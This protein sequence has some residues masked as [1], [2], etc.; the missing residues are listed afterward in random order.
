MSIKYP[1]LISIVFAFKRNIDFSH[2]LSNKQ[3]DLMLIDADGLSAYAHAAI[4][5]NVQLC[6]QLECLVLKKA[7]QLHHFSS[8]QVRQALN[9][10]HKQ[11][12]VHLDVIF[13]HKSINTQSEHSPAAWFNFWGEFMAHGGLERVSLPVDGWWQWCDSEW[14]LQEIVEDADSLLPFP[15]SKTH[16]QWIRLR[17][18]RVVSEPAGLVR[19]I[20][21]ACEA[22]SSLDE[23]RMMACFR[24]AVSV[25]METIKNAELP[26]KERHQC[27]EYMQRVILR[28]NDV[29]GEAVASV[30]VN[31]ILQE[32]PT[33]NASTAS[34]P[35]VTK[36]FPLN[37][38]V[39]RQLSRLSS[40]FKR[41]AANE[42]TL[43]YCPV[44]S[45]KLAR[46]DEERAEHLNT[47]LSSISQSSV[48]VVGDR[49]RVHV[50]ETDDIERECPICYEPFLQ[51]QRTVIMNC[52]CR[53]H[54][55]C[56]ERWFIRSPSCPFHTR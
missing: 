51:E 40:L 15:D 39:K 41:R 27:A 24:K 14:T 22:E 31:N 7:L 19:A 52:L 9:I 18:R 25:L 30:N 38:A 23:E 49:Y 20:E 6:L 21:A 16:R 42:E 2:L 3:L 54:E 34:L 1:T 46:S 37:S 33:E 10:F 32:L 53:F 48:A 56:I 50:Q 29:G 5:K 17:R 11:D 36:T 45:A 8:K 28:M 44:C 13:G 47:C 26:A 35:A 55:P 4:Q 12:Q 43:Q